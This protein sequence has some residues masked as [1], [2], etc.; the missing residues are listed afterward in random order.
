MARTDK[1]SDSDLLRL[2][3]EEIA[4]GISFAN[5]LT[6]SGE[7]PKDKARGDRQTALDY[8]EGRMDDLPAEKGRSSVVSR[9]VADVID[10]ML[11]GLMRVFNG[12]DRVVVYAPARPGDEEGAAQATDYVNHVW[13]NECAGYRVLVTGI[14]DALQ[15]RNGII[16]AYWDSTPEHETETL[17][18]LSDEQLV[19]LDDD[20]DVEIVGYAAREEFASDPATGASMPLALHDVK[21]RRVVSRGRLVI[22]NVPP[23]DFGMSRGGKCVDTARVVWHRNTMTRS[24]LVKAGHKR[25]DVW[26]LPLAGG[27]TDDTVDREQY[28]GLT[29]EG[30]GATAEVDIVEAYV[31]ADCD[32]DGIAESR[33]VVLAG[34][35][36]GRKILSNEEWTEDRPFADLTPQIVPHRWMGRSIADNVMDL[37]RVKTAAW[38]GTLDNI[39]A[40]NRPQR[41]VEQAQ[42]IN[43][44]EVL[45]PAFG[46]VIRVKKLGVIREVV[47]PDVTGNTL[48]VIQAVDGVI[49]RR[50]GVAGSTASLDETA[51]EP[52]T[53]TAEQLEH[54][55]SYARVELVARNIADGLRRLFAKVL[56]IVVRNQD[57]PRTIRLRDKWVEFDPR[58][59]NA[60]MDV[61]INIGL[62]TGSR[63]RDLAMLAGV[64]ARQEAI[65]QRLGPDNPVVRP[66]MYVATLHKLV[67]AS[68]IKSPEAYFADVSDEDFATW[69][70]GRPAAPDPKLQAVQAQIEGDRAKAEA[71]MVLERERM[72]IDADLQRERIE[73]DFALRQQEMDLEA[74]LKG[75]EIVAGLRS[76]AATNI[77]RQ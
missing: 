13:L 56:R 28:G 74:R 58:A 15:V 38:R 20:P 75:T 27:R 30:A 43:P 41:E 34:A 49:Q 2:I 62:G 64:A 18:R 3:D 19:M 67:E 50:T 21:L 66:S 65:I 5:D 46:G 77:P 8:Y 69:M 29:S 42:I 32:G 12:S 26:D 59:W 76:P 16:K 14:Y 24:D 71:D 36:G 33:K 7:R 63:E 57:R 51:L 22:E 52:Q 47:T 39:Y 40:Q 25:E 6:A 68:G 61:T 45:N 54:D 53:A 70:A 35:A 4:S 44:D 23:E 10:T 55:A 1:V 73:R 37:Q 48:R 17:T 9:D 60:S 11:P 31:F 72:Q